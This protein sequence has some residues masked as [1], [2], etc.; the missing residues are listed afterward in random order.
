MAEHIV[1]FSQNCQGLSLA[2]KRRDIFQYVR[3]KKYNIICLQ[4][5][6][7]N[8]KMEPFVQ[9]EWGYNAY[10]SSYTTNSRGVM[11]LI[12]NNFE[13][14]V[15]R[16][17]T[18]KNGNFVILDIT[19]QGKKL[20]I[21]N[22]Y[23]PNQD[24]PNFYIN[25]FN[26][27][28]ET[29]NDQL[30]LCGDWNFV[31]DPD[32]D[33]ENYVH[34]NNPRARQVVLNYMEEN[35]ILDIWRI[36]NDNR[37]MFT[38]RRLN[39]VKK[40][41][42]L[43]YFLISENIFQY[44]IDT[45]I[46]SGYRT[47]H[48]GIILKLKLQEGERGRGYWKFNNSLLKD[49]NYI[50]LVK[51]T[52]EETKQ[53]YIINEL[54]IENNNENLTFSINDQLFLET[55]L[56]L[57]RGNTIK[58][59][60]EKK[61]KTQQ[62][63]LKLESEVK[64]LEDELNE[65]LQNISQEKIQQMQQTKAKLV[66]IRQQKIE[67][68]MLRSKCRYQDLGE[69]PTKYFFNLENR[70]YTSKVINKLVEEN[71]EEYIHTDKIL[72]FQKEFYK[73]LYTENTDVIDG[74]IE[75]VIG[76]N[77][78]KLTEAESEGLE[79]KINYSELANALRNMKNNK[80]PG[81]DGFTVEFF[82]FF[83]LDLGNYILR[84]LNYAY[85]NG[86]LSVT[87]KQGIITCLPKPNKNRQQLKN[88][89]PIS[90]LNVIYK[91]ASSVIANRI[92]SV[93]NKIVHVDQKGFLSG[94]FIGENV[95]LMYDVL[96]ETKKQELPGLILS[97]DFE[98]A[99]DTV[100]WKF[101]DKTL[102]YY[103]FGQ[104]IRTWIK[105]FQNGSESCI[106]QNGFMSESF[107]LRR[108]CRQGDPVSP[109]IFILCAEILG[110]MIRQN[111]NIKGISLGNREYKLSQY[112]DDT[113]VFLDG[114]EKSLKETLSILK[115]FYYMS[116]LKIN[117][118]KTRA[119]WIGSLGNSQ[120]QICRE[121]KLDWTQGA[122]KILGVNFSSE[123]FN[124]WDLNQNE[125]INSIERI[126]KQW[127]KRKITLLGRITIVKSLALSKFTHLF[128]ALPNPPGN[129]IKQ[130]ER[131]F[132]KFL[133]NSG[134]DRIKRSIIIKDMNA[135][136]LRMINILN[137]IK[138]LKISWL[139]RAIQNSENC[140][141]I[142]LS[143]VDFQML[144]SLGPGYIPR[145]CE[146][147]SNPFWKDVLRSWACFCEEIKIES[148]CQILNSP[149]WNNTNMVRGQTFYI[150]DWF[151][152]G[153]RQISDLL[154]NQGNFYDFETFKTIFNIR[155]TFLEYNALLT[156]IP[157]E[158]K[159]Q[160]RENRITYILSSFE[161]RCNIYVKYLIK[162]KKGCRRFYDIMTK[163]NETTIQD[164]WER[165]FG[166]LNE[167]EYKTRNKLLKQLNEVALKDFQYK[168]NT[169]ILVTKSFL[170]RINKI[171][172]NRCTY[173]NNHIETIQHLFAEC[174]VVKQFWQ[175]L[176]DWIMVNTNLNLQLDDKSIIFSYHNQHEILNFV[177]IL[178]KQYIYKTKFL[179]NQL[180]LGTFI[181]ILKGKFICEKFIASINNKM[182][183][184][185]SKWRPLYNVF[186]RDQSR[187]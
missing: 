140:T 40:Q 104:S 30:I 93:L 57:I 13:Q 53:T 163:T 60:A 67:G 76:E 131:M 72:N 106:I 170:Y 49:K 96:F 4:D 147:I 175:L 14:K 42:R 95:R 35:N 33:Y 179:N 121:Y 5:V 15:D 45:E 25:L 126:L 141:W 47:D 171:D 102:K 62:E 152:K 130:L 100:S 1:I 65:N 6:H 23:G 101:I 154:D 127:T 39:P 169:K 59:S 148:V 120:R 87:Q 146:D 37:K 28:T 155:G 123:V 41:A 97:I 64:Q 142:N 132:Y 138:A 3:N 75:T 129:L 55:L 24:N 177:L 83:W 150:K 18:D 173:C 164:K 139:R 20:T 111:K 89:R 11:I 182:A 88:W 66:N 180:H 135:G 51:K 12:N 69:K 29:E 168:I 50:D 73:C 27:I 178:A 34:V 151:E 157:E 90:L 54:E 158:W 44:A 77:H 22:V 9:A 128:L 68:V 133:W 156:K 114:T 19:V 21:A 81:Q 153:I 112:A 144:F 56:M 52:I 160:I 145:L 32:I 91:M 31:M 162:D 124:I 122:F 10:F 105:L 108:G 167:Q 187:D 176:K 63:E 84:S 2:A 58:F 86:S 118:E 183:R 136:G 17:I 165:E 48:N 172:N 116:G 115:E 70:N 43:D 80:S 94:R 134:P 143:H 103:N 79:G 184:F 109:Y 46:I 181:S 26:K 107:C 36:M 7:I 117:V 99:F 8:S 74:E 71:G 38:W 110:N 125:I 137:F 186:I 78:S 174:N 119:I 149:I 92:K 82:K 159:I 161:V 113:Q 166:N 61:R 185:L 85:E 98:K 16:I